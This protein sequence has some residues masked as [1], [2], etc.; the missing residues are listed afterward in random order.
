MSNERGHQEPAAAAASSSAS[1][2][3]DESFAILA[4][5]LDLG[6]DAYGWLESSAEEQ[7]QG[8]DRMV[9][10]TLPS[11]ASTLPQSSLGPVSNSAASSPAASPR[12]IGQPRKRKSPQHGSQSCQVG[13]AGGGRGQHG[14]Q[15]CPV[16]GAGGGR[17]DPELDRG[18]TS[19]NRKPSKKGGA[20]TGAASLERDAR[21]AEQLLNPCAAAVEAGNL[22][23]AQHL[24]YV[25]GELASFS[26]EPNHRLAAHGLRF[27]S[28]RHLPAG[29]GQAAAA[30]TMKILSFECPTPAF[31]GVDPRLFRASLIRFN[32][33]SPWFAVPN[34]LANAAIAQ[35][36]ASTTATSEPR[37]IHVVDM[38]V[39][40]GVQWPTLLEALTRVPRGSTPPSVR[41][42]T[43]TG[44]AV[45]SSPP[46]PFSASPPGYDCSPQLLRYAKTINLDLAI[47]HAPSLDTLHGTVAAG[48]TLVV[49][50][51]FRLGHATADE[52]LT[53]LRNIRSL[54]PELL[55]L[56]ELDCSCRSDGG[57]ASEFAGSLEHLW[58][59]LD[60]TAAAF[61]GRDADERRVMEAEAG[62]ALM[63]A[64]A[65]RGAAAGGGRE[66][67]RVRL[68]SAGFK[69][70]AF[71]GE[72]VETAKALLRK[73]DGGWEL[74][75]PSPSVGAEVGLRWKGWPVSFCSLWRPAQVGPELMRRGA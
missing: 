22:P 17:G 45:G 7:E 30:A 67:W 2:W 34:A 63:A 73:Y 41:L 55:V 69:A 11:P 36:A 54:N 31:T 3:F 75:P 21:W 48:E 64:T 18:G 47:V 10:E 5:D 51:Q 32:E 19:S 23:R 40:H 33:V 58:L 43:V 72:A 74:V 16:G 26:G 8:I 71:G 50:L 9:T 14:S 13:G 28:L 35:V 60:S 4:A 24:L 66:A 39:S 29:V 53:V 15:S 1:D 42:L 46:V 65:R 6:L 20:K 70:A 52:Q 57:T 59:F 61:K 25:L 27:L 38:G 68:A 12:E 37:R 62:T 49:C 56:A 44:A